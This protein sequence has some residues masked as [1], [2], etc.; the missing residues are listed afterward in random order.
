MKNL[1]FYII[2]LVLLLLTACSSTVM[3][4]KGVNEISYQDL[5][6]SLDNNESFWLITIDSS[7]ELVDEI[8]LT[9]KFEKELAR[10]G[11]QSAVYLNTYDLSESEKGFLSEEYVNIVADGI[12]DFDVG[13][14]VNVSHGSV[15][16]ATTGGS[17]LSSIFKEQLH[18]E[19]EDEIKENISVLFEELNYLEIDYEL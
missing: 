8:G 7:P 14:L 6:N 12:W 13:G 18:E 3:G 10:K 15:Y 4:K 16:Q 11:I 17:F 19:L 5:L 9:K 1:K 2:P